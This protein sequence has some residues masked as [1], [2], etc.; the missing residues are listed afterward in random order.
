MKHVK[1]AIL[2]G[3]LISILFI[4]VNMASAQGQWEVVIPKAI[5]GI[6]VRMAAFH[7]EN[8]G[9]WGGAGDDGAQHYTLDGGKTW[10]MAKTGGC[11][12]SVDVVDV[13]IIWQSCL[14]GTSLTTDGGKNWKVIAKDV[15]GMASIL[16]FAD[17]KTGWVG[18]GTKFKMTSDGGETWSDLALPKDVTAVAAIS[19]RT[20]KDGYLL[21]KSGILYITGDGGK[22]WTSC[23]L[24]LKDPVIQGFGSGGWINETPEAAIR[25]TDANNGLIALGLSDKESMI[26]LRTADGGKSW[27]E[28]AV[29]A[30]K[31]KPFISRDGRFL[32]VSKWQ[33]GLTLLKAK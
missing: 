14:S 11:M 8:F 26:A 4:G 6:K 17:D 3:I 25:F 31:G 7:D 23:P 28:E 24:G 16:A 15:G 13:N 29:P 19:L 20:P 5:E 32:T 2:S 10:T 33:E 12:F 30:K 21:D 18:S 1:S 27:K 22:S 9:V